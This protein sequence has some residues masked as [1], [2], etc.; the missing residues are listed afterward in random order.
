[1]G[2]FNKKQE[3]EDQIVDRLCGNAG[4][5]VAMFQHVF[6]TPAGF[7]SRRAVIFTSSLAGFACH[8]AVK[9]NKESYQLVTTA[10]GRKFYFGDSVNKYLLESTYSTVGSITAVTDVPFEEIREIVRKCAS[11]IGED[12]GYTLGGYNPQ[13]LYRETKECW[14]G[15][16]D[17]MIARYCMTPSEWPLL[18]GI[19]AQN[20]VSIALEGGAP[21]EATGKLSAEVMIYM[22]KL[23]DDSFLT[24]GEE[25]K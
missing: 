20:I 11:V 1:M 10:D 19:V 23:D 8:Q 2:L 16:F 13:L 9:A 24:D 25:S 12:E 5:V 7:D 18:F 15:I 3:P 6:D 17:N 21:K 14:N 4:N 22:S